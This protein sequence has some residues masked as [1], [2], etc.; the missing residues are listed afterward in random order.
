MPRLWPL[1]S[2]IPILGSKIDRDRLNGE[3]KTLIY[4]H[5]SRVSFQLLLHDFTGISECSIMPEYLHHAGIPP[6]CRNISIMP[7]YLRRAGIQW[8]S[9]FQASSHVR[10]QISVHAYAFHEMAVLQCGRNPS[11]SSL[12]SFFHAASER[13]VISLLLCL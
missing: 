11:Y 13:G 8:C 5:P 6:S 3:V 10:W 1:H 2:P 4:L 7:E 12:L 9:S